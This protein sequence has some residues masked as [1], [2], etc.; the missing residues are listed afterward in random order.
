[1]KGVGRAGDTLFLHGGQYLK[2]LYGN[3]KRLSVIKPFDP[4]KSDLCTC[5]LKYSLHPYTGCSHFCLYCYATSYIGRKPSSPKKDFLN[6]LRRDLNYINRE[7]VVEISSSSDPYPPLEEWVMLTRQTLRVLADSKI[8]VLITTKSNIVVR[9]YDLLLRTPS[10][11]MITITT[12]NEELARKLEPGA[13]PPHKRLEA[14]EYLSSKGLP[15]GVRI[16]PIIPGLNDNPLEIEKLIDEISVRGAKHIVTSTYKVRFDN[17]KRMI[18][19]FPKKKMLWKKL[20]FERG[21]R[22][23]GYIYLP[24][25]IR[26][27]LLEPIIKYGLKKG[28]SVATCREGLGAR[29]FKAPSCDG[30]HLIVEH[31]IFNP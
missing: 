10:S 30:Q 26:E 18:K 24:R 7:L 3:V 29:Y 20:Y 12:L 11:I 6:R 21:E 22:L 9:D 25:S 2:H 28:L 19:A 5:R 4:W 23:H 15:V 31:P 16:D 14:I 27:K 13:P 17:Y 1:M 8:K